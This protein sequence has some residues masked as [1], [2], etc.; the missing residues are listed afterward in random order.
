[1]FSERGRPNVPARANLLIAGSIEIEVSQ[2]VALVIDAEAAQ[3]GFLLTER[4][5][6]LELALLSVDLRFK[7][8]KEFTAEEAMQQDRSGRAGKIGR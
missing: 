8:L 3:R 7:R 6:R 2:V 4:R 1:M 5:Q